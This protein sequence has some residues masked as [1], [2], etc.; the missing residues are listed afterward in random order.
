MRVADR[1]RSA[2]PPRHSRPADG[3]YA[4]PMPQG[5]SHTN[6]RVKEDFVP[7]MVTQA[8]AL[9]V[10]AADRLASGRSLDG[11]EDGTGWEPL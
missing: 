4:T 3:A 6:E 9:G 2:W 8:A 1:S 7:A 5:L 10:E 11:L